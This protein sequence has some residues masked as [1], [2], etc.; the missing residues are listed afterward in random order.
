MAAKEVEEYADTNL[1]HLK[2]L[3]LLFAS[4]V[5]SCCAVLKP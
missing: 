3:K 2:V 5:C 4:V 1:A